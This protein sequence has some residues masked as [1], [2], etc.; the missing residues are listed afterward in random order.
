MDTKLFGNIILQNT[1]ST[2]SNTIIELIARLSTVSKTLGGL[3]TRNSEVP[4]TP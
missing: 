3:I 4:E 1:S 2:T